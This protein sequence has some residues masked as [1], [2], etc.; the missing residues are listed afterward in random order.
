MKIGQNFT[1]EE[2]KKLAL[3]VEKPE[4]ETMQ[5]L[6]ISKQQTEF[7]G[8]E[9]CTPTD[10]RCNPDTACG[11]DNPDDNEPDCTPSNP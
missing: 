4:W 2:L 3:E 11:P 1:L 8:S 10:P 5:A 6:P 9:I 7:S